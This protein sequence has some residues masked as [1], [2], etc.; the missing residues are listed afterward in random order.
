[1]SVAL[2][3][4]MYNALRYIGVPPAKAWSAAMQ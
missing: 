4:R 2:R 1:M 3:L